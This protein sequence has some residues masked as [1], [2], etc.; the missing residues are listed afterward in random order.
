[1][2]I[3]FVSG[4]NTDLEAGDQWWLPGASWDRHDAGLTMAF[5]MP[6]LGTWKHL[7]CELDAAPGGGNTRSF[8][9]YKGGVA[10]ALAVAFGAADVQKSNLV[11]NVSVIAGDMIGFV[12][13][14]T[15]APANTPFRFAS[16]F[17][18]AVDGVQP[19][20]GFHT[21]THDAPGLTW[22]SI[23]G[24]G[25]TPASAGGT[26][27]QSQT[28]IPFPGK[29]K[30]LYAHH[31][32]GDIPGGS[33]V[34]LTLRVNGLDTALTLAWNGTDED[35]SDI[36]TEVPVVAGDYVCF[37]GTGTGATHVGLHHS[38][39][40]IPDD[41]RFWFLCRP[42]NTDV[43]TAGAVTYSTPNLGWLE[44]GDH[45]PAVE[46]DTPFPKGVVITGIAARLG[47]APG[48]GTSRTL[49]V[50]QNNVNTP[51][52]VTISNLATYGIASG[53][54]V[55]ADDFDMFAVSNIRTGLAAASGGTFAIFGLGGV[56]PFRQHYAF[57]RAER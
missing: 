9:V 30:Y 37:Q 10:S 36:V 21:C 29:F 5:P 14:V 31:H 7:L 48:A 51:V 8:S 3:P 42:R 11:N 25:S 53:F 47:A 35:K 38:I 13:K 41:P 44:A 43:L 26:E 49:T 33:T 54:A 19:F 28:L 34:A 27:G 55:E 24:G 6:C 17:E 57:G 22:S 50:R 32:D 1:M 4:A 15:G 2:K 18:P 45:W 40:F 56:D 23:A 52:A 12:S 39:C 20:F 46:Y 16:I